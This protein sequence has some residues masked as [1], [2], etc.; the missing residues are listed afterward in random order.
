MWFSGLM[1]G[2]LMTTMLHPTAGRELVWQDEFNRWRPAWSTRQTWFTEK[3]SCARAAGS[4]ARTRD[5]ELILSVQPDPENAGK[6]LTGHIGTQ[7][8][9]VFSGYGSY[10]VAKVAFPRVPGVLCGWWLAP[11]EDYTSDDPATPANERGSEVDIAENGGRRVVHHTIWYRDPGQGA[12]QFHEPA[13]HFATNLGY[14]KAQADYHT[15]GVLVEE[16]GYTFDVDGKPVGRITEGISDGPW[17]LVFSIKLPD[18]LLDTFDPAT[19][20]EQKMRVKWVRAYR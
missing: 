7:G 17:F 3:Q 5:G 4:C 20:R 1:T 10:F 19:I 11:A 18:Y 6:Y 16:D 8:A 9:K 15:Y 12:E 14:P 2:L 13:P